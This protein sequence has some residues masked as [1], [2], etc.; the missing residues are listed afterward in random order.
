ME[1][2][3]NLHITKVDCTY[4]FLMMYCSVENLYLTVMYLIHVKTI[5][6]V[7]LSLSRT[8]EHL[9]WM[10]DVC[11][12]HPRCKRLGENY[13]LYLFL[14][15]GTGQAKGFSSPPFMHIE[16]RMDSELMALSVV[17]DSSLSDSSNST[18]SSS[19]SLPVGKYKNRRLI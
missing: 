10:P 11:N 14:Q 9:L 7:L 4:A 15:P 19:H 8:S 6:L 16:L 5:Y 13:T 3:V 12:W 17:H 1:N 2:S 18:S